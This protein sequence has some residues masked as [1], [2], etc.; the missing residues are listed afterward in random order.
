MLKTPPPTRS[1]PK[2]MTTLLLARHQPTMVRMS[3][4][5]EKSPALRA[6]ARQRLR[7]GAR[8]KPRVSSADLLPDSAQRWGGLVADSSGPAKPGLRA[9]PAGERQALGP[10][11]AQVGD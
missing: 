2:R 9:T 1:S 4:P 8:R 7:E 3:P 11:R 10:H 5:F 6:L